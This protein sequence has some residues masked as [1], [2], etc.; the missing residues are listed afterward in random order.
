MKNSNETNEKAEPVKAPEAKKKSGESHGFTKVLGIIALILVIDA[1]VGA[2]AWFL[3]LQPIVMQGEEEGD[4]DFFGEW[5]PP[6]PIELTDKELAEVIPY[7]EEMAAA[8]DAMPGYSADDTWSIYVYMIGSD[9]ESNRMDNLTALTKGLTEPYLNQNQANS[10]QHKTDNLFKFYDELQSQGV[11]LPAVLYQ[12]VANS[13]D[14]ASD[15][16]SPDDPDS[17]GAATS[18]MKEMFATELSPNVQVVIQTGGAKRWQNLNVN[19]NR[20]Q[21][22]LLN[23]EGFREVYNEAIVSMSVPETL[24]DFLTWS[25]QNYPADHT[26]V[27]LWDHGSGYVGYGL[28]EIYGN[29]LSLRDIHDAFAGAVEANPDAPYFEAI[30]FDACLM[31]SL[32]GRTEEIP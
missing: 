21:R 29:I 28:D 8:I 16:I 5:T 3:L 32:S 15:S 2:A 11:D 13:T 6:T 31:A 24:T 20:S 30:G 4:A 7:P 1:I 18:D 22:F 9:L 25:I 23:K 19:P 10:A 14:Y 17:D 27:V 12:P 26:V